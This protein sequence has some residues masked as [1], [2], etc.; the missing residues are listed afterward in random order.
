MTEVLL[1]KSALQESWSQDAA[2]Q[3]SKPCANLLEG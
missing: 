3:V 2:E 1:N